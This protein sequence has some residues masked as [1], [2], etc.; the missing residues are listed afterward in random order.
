[1]PYYTKD[2]T[3]AY[4][5]D[6]NKTYVLRIGMCTLVDENEQRKLQ[7]FTTHSDRHSVNVVMSS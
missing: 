5:L 1:M 3:P 6:I 7:N 2:A 4:I